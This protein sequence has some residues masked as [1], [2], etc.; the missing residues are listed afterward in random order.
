MDV[1]CPVD[2][3]DR[4]QVKSGPATEDK[5]RCCRASNSLRAAV[6][7]PWQDNRVEIGVRERQQ[8]HHRMQ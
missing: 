4:I 3:L 2:Q 5:R 8:A 1:D 7:Y 6:V